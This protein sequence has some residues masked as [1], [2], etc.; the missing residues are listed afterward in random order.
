MLFS[1]KLCE[2][3]C[4]G[5]EMYSSDERNN[6]QQQQKQQCCMEFVPFIQLAFKSS[7]LEFLCIIWIETMCYIIPLQN[8]AHPKKKTKKKKKKIQMIFSW[9]R[10]NWSIRTM[11]QNVLVHFLC[12]WWKISVTKFMPRKSSEME[13]LGK[14][15]AKKSF[16]DEIVLVH[17]RAE[18]V[19]PEWWLSK[20]ISKWKLLFDECL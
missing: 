11:Y 10:I 12:C 15:W 16:D 6:H 9:C 13:S 20:T 18:K 3:L 2:F 17:K 1:A 5:N 7:F 14:K 8:D 4:N 19:S